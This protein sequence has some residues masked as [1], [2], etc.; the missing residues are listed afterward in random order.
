MLPVVNK[1]SCVFGASYYIPSPSNDG[2]GG[3][4]Q[5]V[6][7][8]FNKYAFGKLLLELIEWEDAMDV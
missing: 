7:Y 4:T 2:D 8:V 5:C 6:L 3:E 1:L